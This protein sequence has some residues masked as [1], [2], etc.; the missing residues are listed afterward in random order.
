VKSAKYDAQA[1]S[2]RKKAAFQETLVAAKGVRLG[3]NALFLRG[4][5][6]ESSFEVTALDQP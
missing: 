3:G 2:Q 4:E 1:R 6:Q 5:S